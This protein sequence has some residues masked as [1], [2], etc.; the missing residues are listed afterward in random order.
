MTDVG[1]IL[2]FYSQVGKYFA[3]TRRRELVCSISR[4]AAT[5]RTVKHDE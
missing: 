4:V 5:V 3:S 2:Y 1:S